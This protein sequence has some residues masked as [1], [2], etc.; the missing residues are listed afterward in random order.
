MT[1]MF[2]NN[3]YDNATV[4]QGHAIAQGN[5]EAAGYF[6]LIA[7]LNLNGEQQFRR[8]ASSASWTKA[9]KSISMP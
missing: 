8:L 6:S 4:F 5:N 3:P 9:A 7:P 1:T 2:N